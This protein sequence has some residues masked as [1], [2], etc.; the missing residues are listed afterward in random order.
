MSVL[1]PGCGF[2]TDLLVPV[3]VDLRFVTVLLP[4]C[5]FV[6]DLFVI[7]VVALRVILELF[8][9]EIAFDLLY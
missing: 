6:T 8:P 5:G 9:D 7:V 1:L 4:G 2:V 3:V